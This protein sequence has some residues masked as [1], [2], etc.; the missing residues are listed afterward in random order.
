MSVFNMVVKPH[1]FAPVLLLAINWAQ[2]ADPEKKYP[3]LGRMRYV[4]MSEDYKQ[5]KILLKDGPGSWTEEDYQKEIMNQIKGHETFVNVEVDSRE[6][7][8]LVATFTPVIDAGY[9]RPLDLDFSKLEEIMREVDEEA[10]ANGMVPITVDPWTIFDNAM[11]DLENGKIIPEVE[12]LKKSFS[13][14]FEN[15]EAQDELS[16]IADDSGVTFNKDRVFTVG[17]DGKMKSMD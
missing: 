17:P 3:H 13:E 14:M 15:I 10:V 6:N 11:K 5:I 4:W 16:G 1:P 7:V 2:P 12:N 8:Y 9:E